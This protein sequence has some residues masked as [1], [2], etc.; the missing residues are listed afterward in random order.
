MIVTISG[1]PGSGKTTVAKILSK[2][3]SFQL[4]TGGEIFRDKARKMKV[5]LARLGSFAERDEKFDRSLDDHLLLLMKN[6]ED[7]VVESRLSGWLC[8]L[9]K[10]EAFK[11]FVSASEEVRV[12]RIRKSLKSRKEEKGSLPILLKEREENEWKRYKKYYGIDY[13]N[14]SI[15]DLIIDST[16]E[17]AE[18]VTEVIIS[19]LDIREGAKAKIH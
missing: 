6:R 15:Y 2:R 9:N 12:E 11:V 17:S 18:K 14:T 16:K 4:I 19:G 7:M 8:Y 5:S 3:L 13:R 1:P 10:I